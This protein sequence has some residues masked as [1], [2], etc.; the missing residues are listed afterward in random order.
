MKVKKITLFFREKNNNNKN[1][2]STNRHRKH[3]HN[4][5]AKRMSMLIVSKM[6]N[7]FNISKLKSLFII[8]I[9]FSLSFFRAVF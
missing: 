2:T 8:W 3:S 1:N 9:F 5:I 4:S 6:F 7:F